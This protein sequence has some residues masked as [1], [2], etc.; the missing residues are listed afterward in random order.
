M[1]VYALLKK[2]YIIK[3]VYLKIIIVLVWY[4]TIMNIGIVYQIIMNVFVILMKINVK[5]ANSVNVVLLIII[6]NKL[7]NKYKINNKYLVKNIK[8][9]CKILNKKLKTIYF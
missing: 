8:N 3:I 1:I 7:H 4:I 9:I 6:S 2:E 5:Y